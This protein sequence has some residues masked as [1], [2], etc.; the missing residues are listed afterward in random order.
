[1]I[2]YQNFLRLGTLHFSPNSAAVQ[3]LVSYMNKTYSTFWSLGIYIHE[4]ESVAE[5]YILTHLEKRTL[6]LIQVSSAEPERVAYTIRQNYTTLPNTNQVASS[7]SLGLDPNYL[8]YFFSG[9]LTLKD[10]VDT[11]AYQYTGTAESTFSANDDWYFASS[12]SNDNVTQSC[13]KP[14]LFFTPYPTQ[15]FDTNLFY[16]QVGFLL[17]LALTSKIR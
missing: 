13:E 17:G 16:T 10:A 11:W 1:M 12:S 14:N 8:L 5:N 7:F 2:Q 6:A 4:S 3:D 9:F 15:A